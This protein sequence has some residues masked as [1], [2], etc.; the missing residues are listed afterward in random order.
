MRRKKKSSANTGTFTTPSHPV[1]FIVSLYTHKHQWNR[2]EFKYTQKTLTCVKVIGKS[3]A[4][5]LSCLSCLEDA[6][7]IPFS[8]HF[9]WTWAYSYLPH[10]RKA[11]IYRAHFTKNMHLHLEA[12]S[13]SQVHI[14][15]IF[16]IMQFT[17]NGD[18]VYVQL[19]TFACMNLLR[20]VIKIK[21]MLFP[22][23]CA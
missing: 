18:R 10:S 20:A 14:K 4:E 11:A 23:Q 3:N 12:H 2:H 22:S 21:R 1:L 6:S 15:Q 13:C 16:Y 8:S 17:I 5:Q 19:A 9:S 7:R